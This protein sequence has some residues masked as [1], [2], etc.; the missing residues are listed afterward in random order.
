[1]RRTFALTAAAPALAAVLALGASPSGSRAQAWSG[2][3]APVCT[4]PGAQSNLRVAA[5]GAGGAYVA[6][7]DQRPG[8]AASDVYLQRLGADGAPAAGWPADG[9]RVCGAASAQLLYAMVADGA[10]GVFLAWEDQRAGE[11]DVYGQRVLAN[12][13]PAPGWPADGLAICDFFG[14]QRDPKLVADGAGGVFCAWADERTYAFSQRDVYA[15]HLQ[16][17]GSAAWATDGVRVTNASTYDWQP[18]AALD[19]AGGLYVAWTRGLAGQDVGAQHLD[20]AGAPAPSWPDTGIVLCGEV[21]DQSG[22][23]LVSGASGAAMAIWKDL[24]NYSPGDT[25]TGYYAVRFGPDTSRAAGWP[26]QGRQFYASTRPIGASMRATSDVA[27]GLLFTWGE[28]VSPTDEDLFLVH[29]DSAGTIVTSGAFPDGVVALCPD[30]A[31]QHPESIETDGAGGA[32][33]SWTDYRED[34]SFANSDPYVQ[35][36]LAGATIAP[37]WPAT[38]V[39]LTQTA[40]REGATVPVA[41]AG[42]VI[43]A[44]MR[45]AA[46]TADVFASFVGDDGVVPVL[47]SLVASEV[48]PA[49]VRLAWEVAGAAGAEWRIERRAERGDW[50]E[51]ARARPDGTGRLWVTDTDVLAGA[52]YAYRVA[53]AAGGAALGETWLEVPRATAAFALRGVWPNPVAGEAR[54]RFAITPGAGPATLALHDVH[55]RERR[56][57]PVGAA[58][59]EG[60]LALDGL[61]ALP[62][63]VYWLR[64]RQGT[65]RAAVRVVVA[66]R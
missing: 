54:A 7:S 44:W 12:G 10:G 43:A 30:A 24:R 13:S 64:L 60:T 47:V 20:A 53:P 50:R 66:G 56:R 9:L 19:G 18:Q 11:Y 28:L 25:E 41:V 59:G 42:G 65:Q 35:H 52:R 33:V 48:S 4:A 39:A 26:H 51:I 32:F 31:Y 3:G 2:A 17:D 36:V 21:L 27:G 37:G 55:G 23:Q 34:P 8:S 40:A 63:G 38:G 29:V 16:G 58:G 15:Q 62:A 46:D 61:D 14:P 5:D 49:R 6:W 22:V 45:G 1:M 57:W